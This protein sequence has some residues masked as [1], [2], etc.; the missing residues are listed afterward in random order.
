MMSKDSMMLPEFKPY[1][2]YAHFSRKKR[3][4][5]NMTYEQIVDYVLDKL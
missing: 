5:D 3:E 4:T 1:S 2:E